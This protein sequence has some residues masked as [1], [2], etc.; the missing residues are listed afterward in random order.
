MNKP[1]VSI[2]IPF[3]NDEKYL[4]SSIVSVLNQK[5]HNWELILIDDGSDD[6][7]YSIAKLYECERVKVVSDGLNKGL[8]ARINETVKMSNGYYYARMDADDIMDVDRIRKQVDFLLQ[9]PETDVVGTMAYVIDDKSKI[10]GRFKKGILNPSNIDDILNGGIFIHPSI[11]GKKEWFLNHPYDERLKRMQD[12]GLWLKTVS[13]SIF[14]I[15]PEELLFY[16]AGGIPT[17]KK[18]KE[19]LKCLKGLYFDIIGK[20]HGRYILAWK[21]YLIA[22]F[23]LIVYYFFDIFDKTDFLVRNRYENVNAFETNNAQERLNKSIEQ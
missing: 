21:S 11:M 10:I 12:K 3:H 22:F 8:A 2:A 4:K 7:S 20:L 18:N 6:T 5:Y 9:N 1:L 23:K 14:N 17:M 15:M 13:T 16:R 19:E